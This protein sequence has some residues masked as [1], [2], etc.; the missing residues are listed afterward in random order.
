VKAGTTNEELA[1]KIA[2]DYG[3]IEVHPFDD[4]KVY[5]VLAEALIQGRLELALMDQPYALDLITTEAGDL[6]RVTVVDDSITPDPPL[7]KIGIGT[8]KFDTELRDVLNK[9]IPN[10][11]PKI[12]NLI[13]SLER[14]RENGS[15]EAV[16][17]DESVLEP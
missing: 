7:E 2:E 8:K 5:D 1:R 12:D 15:N 14:H 16:T 10:A 9:A 13:R 6:L 17:E 11:G 3:A 4:D